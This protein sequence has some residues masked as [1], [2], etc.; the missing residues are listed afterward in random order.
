MT[1]RITT[2]NYELYC[3]A[4]HNNIKINDTLNDELYCDAKNN[5][6]YAECHSVNCH[7]SAVSIMLGVVRQSVVAPEEEVK[8]VSRTK[9]LKIRNFRL[10][11]IVACF[12]SRKIL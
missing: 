7:L 1:F 10:K 12:F 9:T 8:S 4:Q 2:L 11:K 3:D 6:T 5:D